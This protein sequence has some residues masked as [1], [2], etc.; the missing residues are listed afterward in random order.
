MDRLKELDSLRGIACLS[1]LLFHYTTK[2]S[3]IFNTELTVKLLDFKY[4]GLGVD[5]FF[6]ISGFVIFL[7]VKKTTLPID[8]VYKRFS[9]LY[10]TF[11]LCVL[12][13][14]FVVSA[15][16]LVEYHRSVGELLINFTMIP[17]IFGVKRIDGVYWSLLPELAFYFLMFCL[18]LF[19]KIRYIYII[20]CFW[21]LAI[22]VNYFVDIM[23]LRVL[24]NLRF[25]HLFVIGIC[26]YNIK[27]KTDKWWT[28]LLIFLAYFVSIVINDSIAKHIILLGFIGV[29]YLFVYNKL[30]WIK[31]KP[32]IVAGEISYALYLLHQFIGY[33]IIRALLMLKIENNILLILVPTVIVVLLSYFITFYIEKP[34]QLFLRNTWKKF[35]DKK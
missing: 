8:F 11:W 1:V 14:F 15:S 6:I 5:L 10:P 4:G 24:F 17:D 25:G 19:K 32:L 18:I 9:R 33:V 12:I 13:T 22:V 2:Y 3:E 29:F 20:S 31:Q 35:R 7:T 16:G 30:K 34:M 27:S 28:H 26:F 23:P 21:L